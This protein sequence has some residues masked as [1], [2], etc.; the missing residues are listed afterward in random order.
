MITVAHVMGTYLAQSETFIWQYLHRLDHADP[1]IIA[2]SFENLHQFPLPRAKLYATYGPRLTRLWV[3]DNWYRRILR[4]PLGYVKKIINKENVDI[5]HAHFGDLSTSYLPVAISLKIPFITNFYGRDLSSKHIIDRN[6]S[7]YDWLFKKGTLFLVE[8]PCMTEKLVSL[9]CPREKILIQ[10]IA[11]DLSL[12]DFKKRTW[13]EKRPIRLLF[14]GRLVEKKGLEFALRAL[15]RIRNEYPFQ[16]RIIGAGPLEES[17]QSLATSLGFKGETS[18]LGVQ[19]HKR[20]IQELQSCDALIQPSVTARNGDSE[21]GA[22][23]I[24]LEAQACGVPVISTTHADIPYITSPN[25]SALL[26]SERDIEGLANNISHLFA[27]SQVWSGMGE[28]GREHVEKF[29]DVGKEV[30]AL[31]NLYKNLTKR[32]HRISDQCQK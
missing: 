1:V 7:S 28:K 11:L 17:L 18:W 4:N 26:S 22:P 9:G 16:F 13:D 29:H 21:G 8:G 31:E 15:A 2:K 23:T 32:N 19:T 30:V 27:S 24:I 5:V 20:V 25:E 6:R 14:V 12:Y 10:R 3:I